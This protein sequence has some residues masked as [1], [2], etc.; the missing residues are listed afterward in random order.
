M[1]VQTPQGTQANALA[2]A[3][4]WWN[5]GYHDYGTLAVKVGLDIANLEQKKASDPSVVG[6]ARAAAAYVIA[7]KTG[8]D[9]PTGIIAA[10]GNGVGAL[11]FVPSPVDQSGNP[12]PKPGVSQAIEGTVSVAEFL[13]K[14][15]DPFLW[16][17]VAEVA[18]GAILIV[19]AVRMLA[20]E[21]G[22]NIPIPKPPIL[23][24]R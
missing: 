16:V 23:R 4:K 6:R 12:I 20:R 10:I 13:A 14:L 1:P 8:S 2:L 19:I 9:Y 5:A 21:S 18:G 15:S 17:R 11:P 22:V 7:S 24:G 3:L